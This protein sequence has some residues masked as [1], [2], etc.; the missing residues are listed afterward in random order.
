M[1]ILKYIFLFIIANYAISATGATYA[2]EP[3]LTVNAPAQVY[4]GDN[5]QISFSFNAKGS[6]SLKV[7]PFKGFDVSGPFQSQ[8]SNSSY[9]NGKVSHSFT[10][11][12][13]YQL[14]ALKAGTYNIGAASITANGNQY[15]SNPFTVQVV[16]SANRPASQTQQQTRQTQQLQA[17]TDVNISDKDLYVRV[18][19]NKS[20][21]YK[22]E[23]VI[24]TYKLYSAVSLANVSLDRM[25]SFKG[26]WSEE[27]GEVNERK[28]ETINGKTYIVSTFRK[29]AVFPQETGTLSLEPLELN[30]IAQVVTARRRTG[31][32]WDIFDDPFFT[33]V[34]NV[35]KKIKSNTLTIRVK[36]LPEDDMPENFGSTVGDF[37]VTFDRDA[38]KQ[39]VSGEAIT[40]KFTVSGHGN[41]EMITPPDFVFPPDFEVYQP[42]ISS[43]KNAV[44]TGV[45]GSM[46]FEYT[47]IPRSAGRFVIP[48]FDYTFFNPSKHKY[49]TV[50]V[51]E[52]PLDVAQGKENYTA[53]FAGSNRVL[54]NDIEYIKTNTPKFKIADYKFF[55]SLDFFILITVVILLFIASVIT[56]K[57]RAKKQL[58]IAGIRNRKA[59]HKAKK[60]LKKASKF[61]IA[62]R[63]D[64]FYTE[65]SIALWGFIGNKLNIPTAELS[66]DTV[67]GILETRQLNP[68][69]I[70][71]FIQ[72]L[73]DCEFARFAPKGNVAREM[74]YIYNKAIDVIVSFPL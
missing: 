8:S 26:F 25:P 7:P 59:L 68:E 23:E 63:R 45:S 48:S 27:L 9:I 71:Q 20:N 43:E 30:A 65:I 15:S 69:Y 12:Y 39:P 64:E 73:D 49:E 34:Q 11:S 74:Q 51:P 44:A 17:A 10:V 19:A 3:Q 38:A 67:R 31:S 22:G 37:D 16:A 35:E 50:T 1:K 70:T 54:K 56:F 18:T 24:L 57:N 28:Q 4:E 72:T 6:S 53:G 41:I 61:M 60:C 32:I 42:Q 52:I 21:P 14:R 36:D 5:F 2:Q 58:D 46:T 66:R 13:T 47:V 29:V 33:P 40:F 62:N 55:L